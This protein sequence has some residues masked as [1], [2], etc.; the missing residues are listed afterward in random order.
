MRV[1][2]CVAFER[3]DS[4]GVFGHPSRID[5]HIYA[6]VDRNPASITELGNRPKIWFVIPIS[7]EILNL[8][9]KPGTTLPKLIP[10]GFQNIHKEK[11]NR[12]DTMHVEMLKRLT[13][14]LPVVPNELYFGAVQSTEL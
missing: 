12:L 11:I 8:S 13:E 6:D 14:S 2:C 4:F 10:D 9:R 5:A 1:Q 3:L 7:T